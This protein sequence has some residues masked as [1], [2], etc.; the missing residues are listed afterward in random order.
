VFSGE[1]YFLSVSVCAHVF[2]GESYLSVSV[3]AHVGKLQVQVWVLCVEERVCRDRQHIGTG[4]Y[5]AQRQHCQQR[6]LWWRPRTI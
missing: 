1:S 6:F 3:C 5:Q 2:S 4:M